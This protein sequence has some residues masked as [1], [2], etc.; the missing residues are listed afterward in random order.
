VED[1]VDATGQTFDGVYTSWGV[2]AW[3]P[4]ITAWAATI[5]DLLRPGGWVYVAD[6]HPYAMAARGATAFFSDHQGD[7]TSAEATFEHPES[8]EWNHGIGETVTALIAAGMHLD[9]LHEHAEVAWP[10]DP[11]VV[12]QPD[13]MWKVPGS[14]LR[15]HTRA[16]R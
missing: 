16:R 14:T 5:H 9:W 2:L 6:T 15:A 1:A 13:G 10:L 4:D 12:E 8:W 3:L 7:Y 11:H